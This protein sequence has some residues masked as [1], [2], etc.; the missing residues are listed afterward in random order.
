MAMF[1]DVADIKTADQLDLP[2]PIPHFETTVVKP[3]E[4]QTELVQSLSERAAAVH[5]GRVEP[6]E[7]NMLKIVRCKTQKCILSSGERY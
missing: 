5:A 3:T 7:D 4:L 2:R 6:T 1:R